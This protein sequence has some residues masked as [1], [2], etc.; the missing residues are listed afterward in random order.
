MAETLKN[1]LARRMRERKELRVNSGDCIT[2]SGIRMR[3]DG[4][5]TNRCKSGN[6]TVFIVR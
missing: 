1:Y 3:P 2:I 4:S 6:E 5:F